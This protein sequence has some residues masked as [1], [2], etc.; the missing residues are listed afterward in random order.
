MFFTTQLGVSRIYCATIDS[1]DKTSYLF[2]ELHNMV[3][4]RAIRLIYC[5]HCKWNTTSF[6]VTNF[7]NKPLK[8]KYPLSTSKFGILLPIDFSICQNAVKIIYRQT[9][10]FWE[11]VVES[12]PESWAVNQTMNLAFTTSPVSAWWRSIII[13]I[14]ALVPWFQIQTLTQTLALNN[15]PNRQII[16]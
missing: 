16:P 10:A 1:P 8:L 11:K 2:Q 12:H 7:H 6:K 3:L 9:K 4:V 5:C 14:T 13:S 15:T